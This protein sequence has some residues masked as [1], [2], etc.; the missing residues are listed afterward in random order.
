[1]VSSQLLV[2]QWRQAEGEQPILRFPWWGGQ[3]QRCTGSRFLGG[4]QE[5][6]WGTLFLVQKMQTVLLQTQRTG[7]HGS[8][9]EQVIAWGAA[10]SRTT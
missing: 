9:P 8:R 7:L 10:R 5:Y 6:K 1:M 4:R 2:W 3:K